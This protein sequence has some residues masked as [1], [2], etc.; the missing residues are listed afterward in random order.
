MNF[1][2]PANAADLWL[3]IVCLALIVLGVASVIYA[4]RQKPPKKYYLE[5]VDYAAQ[6]K[7]T[8]ARN[9]NKARMG[10]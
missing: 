8:V 6:N 10:M 3:L 7:R 5:H 1:L 4:S 2:D 9:G